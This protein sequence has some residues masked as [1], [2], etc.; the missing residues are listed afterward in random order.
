MWRSSAVHDVQG[1]PRHIPGMQRSGEN[2][3]PVYNRMIDRWFIQGDYARMTYSDRESALRGANSLNR[4]WKLE[5][6]K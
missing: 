4:L 3:Y 2:F 1:D 6:C 5:E